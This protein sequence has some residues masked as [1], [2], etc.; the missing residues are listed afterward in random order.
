MM[1][2]LVQKIMLQPVHNVVNV[3]KLEDR[4]K[5]VLRNEVL[6]E[7]RNALQDVRPLLLS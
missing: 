1:Q 6:V 7:V 2:Y 3:F 5:V 4:V